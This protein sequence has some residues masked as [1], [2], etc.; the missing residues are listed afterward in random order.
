MNSLPSKD[1]EGAIAPTIQ[2]LPDPPCVSESPA[3]AALCHWHGF[4]IAS[5]S[6]ESQYE[7]RRK[8]PYCS[9]AIITGKGSHGVLQAFPKE[10]G[11]YD[12]DSPPNPRERA[13][14]HSVGPP[15][16]SE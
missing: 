5:G 7:R 8:R 13:S 15:W 10:R 4:H 1:A 16:E 11:A 2:Y 14:S 12:P 6:R 9:W 3:D